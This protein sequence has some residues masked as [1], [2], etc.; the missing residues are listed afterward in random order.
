MKAREFRN[1]EVEQIKN[2]IRNLKESLFKFRFQ[3]FTGQLENPMKLRNARRDLARA[4]SVLK[5][6]TSGVK[7]S[8]KKK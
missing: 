2:E 5:E 6:K 3:H 8:G 7:P 4:Y 1:M